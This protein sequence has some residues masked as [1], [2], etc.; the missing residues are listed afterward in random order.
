MQPR[1]R[2]HIIAS[3]FWGFLLTTLLIHPRA[4]EA[5]EKSSASMSTLSEEKRAQLYEHWM[6]LAKIYE[7]LGDHAMAETA[8]NNAQRFAPP[9]AKRAPH[10]RRR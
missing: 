10:Q 5:Q 1:T 7:E 6:A 8:R 3:L 4:L 2:S 9:P